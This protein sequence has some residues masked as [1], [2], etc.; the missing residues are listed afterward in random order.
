MKNNKKTNWNFDIVYAENSNIPHIEIPVDQEMPDK[1]FMFEFKQTGE[2]EPGPSGEDVPICNMDIHIYFDYNH[3]KKVLD[4]DTLNKV[5]VA[6]GL[7][8]IDA[9]TEKGRKITE[10]IT[11]NA[12]LT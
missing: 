8:E 6:F 2:F 11:D 1:L 9:A 12:D 7:E 3:A 10:R 4:T 5:R